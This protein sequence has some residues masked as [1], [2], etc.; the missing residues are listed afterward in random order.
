MGIDDIP[1]KP[2]P[3]RIR[4]RIHSI[5]RATG[6]Y[7]DKILV[8]IAQGESG[9]EI[10]LHSITFALSSAP[11]SKWMEF[12]ESFNRALGRQIESVREMIGL[13]VEIVYQP[14][15]MNVRGQEVTA[16]YPLIDRIVPPEL[17][18]PEVLNLLADVYERVGGREEEYYRQAELL[19]Y[20]RAVAKLA[21]ES[22]F[23]AA[24]D[25]LSEEPF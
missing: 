16:S 14:R 23:R 22:E 8:N 20:G 19:G 10:S 12:V 3:V 2:E 11:S 9:Q 7:G 15:A 4:G 25:F 18:E 24:G 13:T 6:P 5:E 17:P 21:L 1:V